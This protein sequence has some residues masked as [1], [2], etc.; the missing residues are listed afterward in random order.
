MAVL[1]R[2]YN[3]WNN[4]KL[5]RAID[6]KNL[7]VYLFVLIVFAIAWS[8]VK[9]IQDNYQLQKK[10]SVLKQQNEVLQLEND[11]IQL[12][13]SYYQTNE[14]LDLAARQDL[15]RAGPD[16]KV[17]LVPKATALKYIDKNIA[18]NQ[19]DDANKPSSSSRYM[20]NLEA[21]RDFLLGRKILSD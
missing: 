1:N 9:T 13:N 12:Q 11:N 19:E 6:I 14:Y 10:I 20:K 7:P 4:P 16:E 18:G 15:G 21:W 3:L 17:M 2:I 5:R 8:G